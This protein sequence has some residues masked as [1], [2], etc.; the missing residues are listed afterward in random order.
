MFSPT[1]RAGEA[2]GCA[3]EGAVPSPCGRF[4]AAFLFFFFRFNKPERFVVVVFR[5]IKLEPDLA[6]ST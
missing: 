1:G 5:F 2:E 6:R 3:T 4:P